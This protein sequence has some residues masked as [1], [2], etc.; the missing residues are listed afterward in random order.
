MLYAPDTL[1]DWW[2]LDK[3]ATKLADA[4]AAIDNDAQAANE[5]G[6]S[7][8]KAGEIISAFY[9]KGKQNAT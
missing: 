2:R 9:G 5:L 6:L 4:G 7:R 8:L 3:L 1:E